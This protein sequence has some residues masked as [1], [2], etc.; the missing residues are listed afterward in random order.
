VRASAE[1]E[2][3]VAEDWTHGTKVG[4]AIGAHRR[5]KRNRDSARTDEETTP[6]RGEVGSAL[7]K[8]GPARHFDL[9][10]FLSA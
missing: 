5:E 9:S 3:R 2:I 7:L 6:G 8:L 10:I 1:V 4:R